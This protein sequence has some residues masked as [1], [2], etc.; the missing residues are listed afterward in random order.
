M[1]IT[2]TVTYLGY[3]MP[4]ISQSLL[5]YDEICRRF[6]NFARACINHDTPLVRFIALNGIHHAKTFQ[7]LGHNVWFCSQE[8]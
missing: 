7:F 3:L 2:A 4:V 5:M 8:I 6:L 1:E